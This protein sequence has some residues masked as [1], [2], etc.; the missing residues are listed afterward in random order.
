MLMAGGRPK[1]II[2]YTL[3]DKLA[4]IMATQEEIAS[5][6][7]ISLRCLQQDLEFMRVYKKGLENGR[8]SLRRIQ[9]KIAE[10][11]VGMAIFLGK[12]YL[13]QSDKQDHEIRGDMAIKVVWE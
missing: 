6:M 11:N 1:K 2:D 10:T 3:V 8:M 4:R 12:N 5:F 13:G 7:D 9:W